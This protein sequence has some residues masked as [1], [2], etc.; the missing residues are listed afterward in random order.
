VKRSREGCVRAPGTWESSGMIDA[1]RL[2][3]EDWWLLDV[4]AHDQTAP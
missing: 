1:S 3:G 2:L 4:Q